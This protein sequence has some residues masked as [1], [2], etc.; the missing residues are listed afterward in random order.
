MP[1]WDKNDP[2]TFAGVSETGV[3]VSVETAHWTQRQGYDLYM[4]TRCNMAGICLLFFLVFPDQ[5]RSQ[6]TSL[7]SL[8]D[9]IRKLAERVTPAVVRIHAVEISA[10]GSASNRLRSSRASGSG[11]LVDPGHIVTNAHVVG[12]ARRV[13]VMLTQSSGEL[14]RF[15]SVLKPSGKIV[16]AEFLGV[17]RETDRTCCRRMSSMGAIAA[18]F[19]TSPSSK[20]CSQASPRAVQSP[21][22]LSAADNSSSSSWTPSSS[23]DAIGFPQGRNDT[24]PACWRGTARRQIMLTGLAGTRRFPQLFEGG[25]L[26]NDELPAECSSRAGKNAAVAE[27]QIGT[28]LY[29][30]SFATGLHSSLFV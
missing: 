29:D 30:A 12:T 24:S 15:H 20:P 4:G 5:A 16:T 21:C 7:R 2:D 17:D 11:V 8:G 6:T 26:A 19:A 25:S 13:Q 3:G 27:D 22:I 1:R 23:Q 9:S 18:R 28:V 10:A 14:G